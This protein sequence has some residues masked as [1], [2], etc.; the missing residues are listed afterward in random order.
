MGR[1]GEA[2][3]D[4]HLQDGTE[5]KTTKSIQ[6]AEFGYQHTLV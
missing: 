2:S 3:G 4:L 5:K 1:D 6:N